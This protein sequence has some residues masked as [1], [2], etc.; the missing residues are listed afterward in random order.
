MSQSELRITV[1][2]VTCFLL[3]AC[4]EKS[5]IF[6]NQWLKFVISYKSVDAGKS[7][8]NTSSL[9]A[10][11]YR[12]SHAVDRFIATYLWEQQIHEENL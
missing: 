9:L 6:D 10:S 2:Q 7:Y 11:E 5:A 1:L 4:V 8:Q 12:N 3:T